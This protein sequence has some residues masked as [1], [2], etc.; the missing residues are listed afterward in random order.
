M[1][2]LD[3]YLIKSVLVTFVFCMLLFT[4]VSVAVDIS[5][6]TDDFAKT[7]LSAMQILTQYYFG[8]VPFIWGLLF[9]LFVFIAVI[10]FTSR[11]ANR[12]EVIAILANGTSYN[13]FLLPY[14]IVGTF[15]AAILWV[16]GRYIIPQANVRK[17]EFQTK[18]FDK[19]DPTKNR[20]FNNCTNCFYLKIDSNTYVGLKSYNEETRSSGQFF[21]HRLKNDKLIYNL[22]SDNAA[23]DTATKSWQLTNAIERKLDSLGE[24]VSQ[25]PTYKLKISLNPVELRRDEY[26][27]D[28]LTTPQLNANI[29]RNKLRGSEGLNTLLVEKYR[30]TSTAFSV[31]LLT[32]IGAVIASRKTRGGSGIHL[33]LGIVIAA[34][35][36]VSD[37]F[38]T[39]FATKG[40]LSP[41]LAAWIPN[42]VFFFVAI[43]LY[44]RA[45]K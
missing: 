43:I 44:R 13:R 15:L 23:W 4:L 32:F 41:M 38:S 3:K 24:R 22:R 26:L 21:L 40:N 25:H 5:E 14:I 42:I 27:K 6:K 35:F 10:F 8:F 11:L 19:N 16:G 29:E 34:V 31:I 20:Q 12:S 1:Y 36:I 39:V 30:R 17:G 28:R 33:A 9:P 18:Y 45:P 2:I 7:G 37:R